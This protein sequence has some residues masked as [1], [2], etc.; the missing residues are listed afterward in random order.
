MWDHLLLEGYLT[1]SSVL[2][3]WTGP[4]SFSGQCPSP[5]STVEAGLCVLGL[6][7]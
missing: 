7:L 6:A 2:P 4:E 1:Y 3:R 5:L